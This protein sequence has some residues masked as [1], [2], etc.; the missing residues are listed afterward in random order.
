MRLE[1][2]KEEEVFDASKLTTLELLREL[3]EL[4]RQTASLDAAPEQQL[5]SKEVVDEDEDE[6][7]DGNE[8]SLSEE[9]SKAM[10]H[11]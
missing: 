9:E 2:V 4:R 7:D 1:E 11:W 8:F 5:A 6:N 3:E 10:A